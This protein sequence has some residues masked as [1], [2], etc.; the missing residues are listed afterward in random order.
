METRPGGVVEHKHYVNAAGL[1]GVH[2]KNNQGTDEMRYFHRDNVGSIVAVANNAGA[3]LEPLAYEAF[4]KRRYPNGTPDPGNALI[5]VT[6]DRGF[7]GHEHL[8]EIGL[9]HM[10]GASTTRS[11]GAS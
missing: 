7:T 4:G 8:D 6:T 9:I 2:V 10:K 3:T 11:S 1:V 5:G